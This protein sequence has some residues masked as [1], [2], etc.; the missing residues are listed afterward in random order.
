MRFKTIESSINK[1]SIELMEHL[2]FII[3]SNT[4]WTYKYF[5]W[6]NNFIIVSHRSHWTCAHWIMKRQFIYRNWIYN[7]E[8]RKSFCIYG[9]LVDLS[10]SFYLSTNELCFRC[11][12]SMLTFEFCFMSGSPLIR[13]KS[14]MKLLAFNYFIC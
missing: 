4:C 10:T 6:F 9:D 1:L 8:S 13:F 11:P 3:E 14:L 7:L 12:A 5:C 2:R